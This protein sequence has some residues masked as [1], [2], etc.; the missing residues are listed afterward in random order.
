MSLPGVSSAGKTVLVAAAL[1]S[2]LLSFG[3][4]L[5]FLLHKEARSPEL[6]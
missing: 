2:L 1:G 3:D 4:D 5:R 6:T